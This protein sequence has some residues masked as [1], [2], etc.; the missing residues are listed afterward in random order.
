MPAAPKRWGRQLHCLAALNAG[1]PVEALSCQPEL[2][3]RI[4]DIDECKIACDKRDSQT[5][6][7]GR[8]GFMAAVAH[9]ADSGLVLAARLEPGNAKPGS[10]KLG[11]LELT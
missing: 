6:Y 2:R 9:D 4:V 5:M 10:G 11:L 8:R 3:R 7:D 1:L